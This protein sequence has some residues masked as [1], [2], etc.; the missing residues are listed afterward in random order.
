MS[1]YHE[2]IN[3]LSA[4][5]RE[6]LEVMLRDSAH[7]QA[8]EAE[9]EAKHPTHRNGRNG[10]MLPL[11]SLQDVETTLSLLQ[12]I[13]YGAALVPAEGIHARFHDAGHILGSLINRSLW[14]ACAASNSLTTNQSTCNIWRGRV[15]T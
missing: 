15:N 6:L 8:K 12:P 9:W 7:I 3:N 11:Y 10:Q 1:S 14:R 5:K 2:Q 13:Q 4:E